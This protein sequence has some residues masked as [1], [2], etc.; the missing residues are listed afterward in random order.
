MEANKLSRVDGTP[1]YHYTDAAGLNGILANRNLWLTDRSHL[2]DPTEV[3]YGLQFAENALDREADSDNGLRRLFC[4][5]MSEGLKR[6]PPKLAYYVGSMSLAN[7]L[8]TQWCKYADG[9][10]GYCIEFSATAFD[11]ICATYCGSLRV[12]VHKMDYDKSAI[13]KRQE[14]AIREVLRLIDDPAT[15]D[16]ITPDNCQGFVKELWTLLATLLLWNA[17][18]F[19]DEKYHSEEEARVLL[20]GPLKEVIQDPAHRTRIRRAELV[21]F[22]D[23]AFMCPPTSR[24]ISTITVGPTAPDAAIDAVQRLLLSNGHIDVQVNRSDLP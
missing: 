11:N 23:M 17:L 2:N 16:A 1:L 15:R 8:P 24:I 5:G 19:K 10:R 14:A 22:F 18:P 13:R 12:S 4:S 3:N 7:N 20:F 9:G 6:A 21:P